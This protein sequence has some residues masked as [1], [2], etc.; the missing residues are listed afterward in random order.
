MGGAAAVGEE[1]APAVEPVPMGRRKL[2]EVDVR[3]L[4][5][6]LLHWSGGDDFGRDAPGEDGAADLDQLAGMGVG[7]Q[8]QH[9]GDAAVV[10][11]RGTED[12]PA[13][14]RGG[15]VVPEVVVG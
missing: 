6:V 7:R 14:A 11:E 5:N 13:A 10:V 1:M 4:E 15:G 12:A 2:V 3:A 9:H 8:P